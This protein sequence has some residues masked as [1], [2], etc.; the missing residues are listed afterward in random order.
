MARPG[1]VRVALGAPLRLRGEDYTALAKQVEEQVRSLSLRGRNF[2][3][4][5]VHTYYR[6]PPNITIY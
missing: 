1:R 4:R 5:S 3:C 2:C 6:F